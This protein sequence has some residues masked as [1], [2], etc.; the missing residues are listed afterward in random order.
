MPVT[1][2]RDWS[3]DDVAA[4]LA[5][6]ELDQYIPQIRTEKIDGSTLLECRIEDLVELGLK[7]YHA[8]RLVASFKK[9]ADAFP[10]ARSHRSVLSQSAGGAGGGGGERVGDSE[11]LRV[12]Y[13]LL[14]VLGGGTPAPVPAP[15]LAPAPALSPAPAPA[16]PPAPAPVL[17]PAPA[18][19]SVPPPRPSDAALCALLEKVGGTFEQ[20]VHARELDWENKNLNADDAKVVAYV[21]AVNSSLATLR[22]A[23]T[24]NRSQSVRFCVSAP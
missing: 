2:P 14:R 20:A 21:V 11:L 8:A 15:A 9:A 3:V 19:A 4:F 18:P 5:E 24:S 6:K 22:Y 1:D 16:P 23:A 7:G 10:P 12:L 17:P 13:E